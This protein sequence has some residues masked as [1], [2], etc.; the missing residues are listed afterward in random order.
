MRTNLPVTQVEYPVGDDV[1]IVSKTDTKGKLVYFNEEFVKAAGFTEAELIDQPHNIIRHPDMPEQ[2]F[3]DFWRTLKA[4]KPWVGAV[5]NR[6]EN[7]DFY[8]VLASATPIWE[9]GQ[10]TGYMS[11]RSKLA[12]EQRR[13]AEQV[14][15]L[16]RANKAA[17][18]RIDA[19]VLRRRSLFD[20]LAIFSRTLRA[21]LTT[22]VAVQAGFLMLMGLVGMLVAQNINTHT[23]SIY[24]DRAVS[25]AQLFEVN[26]RMKEAA[27]VLFQAAIDGKAGKPVIEV[28]DKILTNTDAIGKVWAEYMATYLTP[29]EKAAA[30]AFVEKRKLYRDGAIIAGLPLLAEGRFDELASLQAGKGRELFVAAK[31]ELDKL[32]AIQ[33][34]E[35]KSEFEA[36]QREY[37]VA[38][39]VSLGLLCFG[40]ALG[41]AIGLQAIRAITRPVTHLNAIL[42]EIG[43]GRLNSRIRVERD[44]EIGNA[45]RSVQAMQSQL[46]FDIEQRGER[47]R[48]SETE[49]AKALNDMA[50]TVERETVTAVGNVSS[51]M[52]R[53]AESASLMSDSAATVETNSG[54]V[55]AAAEEAL[56][57]AQT[58]TH[59]ASHLN[60]SIGEIAGQIKSS[61]ALT[62]EAVSS[63]SRAQATMGKLSDAANKVGAVTNLIS[64]IASQTNLLALNATIE[65]ARAGEAGR[66]FAVVAQE[67]KSLAEQT[68]KATS[69]IA[70]Q[71]NEI[72]EA[73]RESV[74]SISAIGDI[75]RGVDTFSSQ[76]ASAMEEQS[77]VTQ[78]I[79]R[80]VAESA[81]AAREVAAQIT[82]VSSE[83]VETGRRAA[84]IRS[85]T[86]VIAK[87]V[88]A[89]RAML[90]RVV[91][92]ST[93]DVNRRGSPRADVER[94]GTVQVGGKS[95]PVRVCNLSESG[96]I[97]V[98]AVDVA[99][100]GS[101]VTVSIDG[102]APS[103]GGVV[104]RSDQRGTLVQFELTSSVQELVRA[105][106][107][108]QSAAA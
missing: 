46:A 98:D 20:S 23:R 34:K 55:A 85:S 81:E 93:T 8:W 15:A 80:T 71:I 70:Q 78:E 105:L 12:A 91:R 49:K 11:I 95:H 79:S 33:V 101:P 62:I 59:A 21:R 75:I 5:K 17:D 63:S 106:I 45:L 97:L 50:S 30:D 100:V 35:A 92:T 19:G 26:D 52:E 69:E 43:K 83:A 3:A 107:S 61:R 31:V 58:L 74:T 37:V 40:L 22:L 14:Y 87:E 60:N 32:V 73:T 7:G 104:M 94:P 67:V 24:E 4:G 90:I 28:K 68:A 64:E 108:R 36:A 84:D 2:A 76:I 41:G 102:L 54:S 47:I 88:D 16:M 56:T 57:S 18:W 53:M 48:I 9:Q 42:G 39:G 10:V 25:L 89:L 38:L 65:A 72:Q 77:A 82:N 6:R 86:V 1:V 66:G 29:E 96:V 27:I 99:A 103:L 44:D 51:Q 13:E